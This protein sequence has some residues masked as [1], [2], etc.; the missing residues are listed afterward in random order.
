[1]APTIYQV[2]LWKELKACK[3]RKEVKGRVIITARCDS[4]VQSREW[5][6]ADTLRSVHMQEHK[7]G[8]SS[9]LKGRERHSKHQFRMQTPGQW[10]GGVKFEVKEPKGR[11]N[12]KTLNR[13]KSCFRKYTANAS[14]LSSHQV[15]LTHW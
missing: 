15:F 6:A 9:K 2:R 5:S 8:N 13:S 10:G 14:Q 11:D 4:Q 12:R 1:M 3:K 7:R